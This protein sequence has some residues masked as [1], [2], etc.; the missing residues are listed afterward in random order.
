M[1]AVSDQFPGSRADIDL[2][3]SRCYKPNH[4]DGTC[5]VLMDLLFDYG[6]SP[7]LG[8]DYSRGSLAMGWQAQATAE[9]GL[10]EETWPNEN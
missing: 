4:H 9:K 3:V 7:I 8:R 5:P 2:G 1:V 6:G 10:G